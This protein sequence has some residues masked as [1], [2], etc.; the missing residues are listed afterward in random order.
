[1]IAVA[2]LIALLAIT[3]LAEGEDLTVRLAKGDCLWEN[4]TVDSDGNV[5]QYCSIAVDSNGKAHIA[6][7]ELAREP[8][9][10]K[11]LLTKVVELIHGKTVPY[12]NLKY[13]NNANGAWRV[14][15]LD[16][17]S[18]MIPRIFVDKNNNLHIIHSKLGV[19]D[20]STV[21]DLKY[22][23]NKSGSW[24]TAAIESGVVKGSDSSIVVDS[25]GKV[26]I[27]CRNEEGVGSPGGGQ[28]GLRYITD[29]SGE[30]TWYDVDTSQTTG[31]DGDIAL[32]KDGRV[33]I[34]YLDKNAGLKYATNSD[35]SWKGDVLDKTTSV[36]WN[37]SIAVDSNN[38]VH[39]SYSD[40]SPL[41]PN[42]NP[43]GNGY[44]KYATNVSGEWVIHV[45]D[46]QNAGTFTGLAVD[47]QDNVHIAY[48]TSDG[49]SSTLM[50][51]INS[52]GSWVKETVDDDE[53]GAVGIYCA[54]AVDSD[55]HPHISHYDYNNQLLK[56]ARRR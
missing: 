45:V 22:T 15:T 40:P 5:G 17:G 55:G 29:A 30:W 42:V 35:G 47:G 56:Y 26:H 1:M 39:I 27:S 19:S 34:S 52:Q 31:N 20:T 2:G 44:L 16:T 18:G 12:G 13:A 10:L 33:H 25:N 8:N 6:Y 54:I 46:D 32:D 48:H 4:A 9:L 51:A 53:R 43:P 21:L 14:F 23:T 36:G 37:S 24:E 49:A 28:G 38:K 41:A 50:Y 7:F 11:H 3:S